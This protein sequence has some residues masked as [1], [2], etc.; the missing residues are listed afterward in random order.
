MLLTRPSTSLNNS[1]L[2]ISQRTLVLEVFPRNSATNLRRS[3]CYELLHF[4]VF[5]VPFLL[6]L[7]HP[8]FIGRRVLVD[9][10]HFHRPPCPTI[11]PGDSSVTS[12]RQEL[13][14]ILCVASP[15]LCVR[16]LAMAHRP[17]IW[18]RIGTRISV[19]VADQRVAHSFA[20]SASSSKPWS[21]RRFGHVRLFI[22]L[23]R[24]A[25]DWRKKKKKIT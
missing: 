6:S 10:P 14:L 18:S 4:V 22:G 24:P 17:G 19:C 16:W 11:L 8:S 20:P 2:F 21:V 13:C 9:T 1:A 12:S 7:P 3:L 5:Q 25:S 23:M 15:S